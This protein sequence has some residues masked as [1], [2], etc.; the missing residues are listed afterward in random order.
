MKVVVDPLSLP[1]IDGT[2]VDFVKQGANEAFKF[3][4]PNAKGECGCGGKLL[5][6]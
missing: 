3:Q 5:T 2:L 1:L 6:S 4:N